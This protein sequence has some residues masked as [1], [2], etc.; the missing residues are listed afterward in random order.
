[1][2][3]HKVLLALL[4]VFG[5]LCGALSVATILSLKQMGVRQSNKLNTVLLMSERAWLYQSLASSMANYLAVNIQLLM[6][7]EPSSL[8]LATAADVLGSSQDWLDVVKEVEMKSSLISAIDPT[9]NYWQ[10]ADMSRE[11]PELAGGQSLK[12]QLDITFV[13]LLKLD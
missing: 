2:R 11:I 6:G 9:E 1:M 7:Q 12:T 8:H 3:E 5:V 10:E 13:D 4:V